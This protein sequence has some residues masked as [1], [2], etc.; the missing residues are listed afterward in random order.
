[1]AMAGQSNWPSSTV[2]CCNCNSANASNIIYPFLKLKFPFRFHEADLPWSVV[3]C[4]LIKIIL[5]WVMGNTCQQTSWEHLLW[6]TKLPILS[7][8]TRKWITREQK[9]CHQSPSNP[10]AFL[11]PTALSPNLQS[12]FSKQSSLLEGQSSYLS[13]ADLLSDFIEIIEPHTLS[14][15]DFLLDIRTWFFPLS[16]FLFPMLQFKTV[17]IAF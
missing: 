13:A 14:Y 12:S 6:P 3:S 17:V 7:E 10:T 2:P 8:M 16:L 1:M 9:A 4:S 5:G 11:L 15:S